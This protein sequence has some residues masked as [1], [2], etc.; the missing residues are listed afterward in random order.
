MRTHKSALNDTLDLPVHYRVDR[1]F[2]YSVYCDGFNSRG[3]MDDMA[4]SVRNV[5]DI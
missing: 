3:A 5:K 2:V 1:L 4:V